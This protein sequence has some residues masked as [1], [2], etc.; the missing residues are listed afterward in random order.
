[1]AIAIAAHIIAAVIWVGGMFFAWMVLRP[2]AATRLEP[3]TRLNLWLGVFDRFFPWVWTAVAI[4]LISGFWIILRVY[5][6]FSSVGPHIHAM[7]TIGIIMML[8][9]AHLYFAPY[10]RLKTAVGSE[11]WPEGARHLGMIRR[12]VGINLIL[13]VITVVVGASGRYLI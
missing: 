13:G 12:M 8:I 5:G 10:R 9:F 2:I 3:P 7:M 11:N 6:G 1:M 4:L